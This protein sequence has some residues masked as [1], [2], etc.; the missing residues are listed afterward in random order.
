MQSISQMKLKRWVTLDLSYNEFWIIWIKAIA[1]NLEL[2]NGVWLRLCHNKIWSEW[3]KL[4]LN[5]NLKEWV[6]LNLS[7]CELW[8][9]WAEII[10]KIKL[11]E[12]VVLD[13]WENK[14]WDE[15]LEAIMKNMELKDGVKLGLS[16]NEISEDMKW[17]LKKREKSCRDRW[18]NC[19]V[20]INY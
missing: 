9:K 18:I 6:F 20:D 5:I 8:D 15:W 13:L 19:S 16:G 11:K 10:S 4:I 17:K 2:Q 12:W 14:I 1:D 7:G 3:A